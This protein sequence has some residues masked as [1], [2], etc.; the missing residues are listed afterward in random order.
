MVLAVVTVA[1]P[2]RNCWSRTRVE[3]GGNLVIELS[4]SATPGDLG[5]GE[6]DEDG[7]CGVDAGNRGACAK[8]VSGEPGADSGAV[9]LN[10]IPSPQFCGA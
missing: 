2:G 1:S 5:A 8:C 3:A 4:E 9:L 6:K 7:L 10:R